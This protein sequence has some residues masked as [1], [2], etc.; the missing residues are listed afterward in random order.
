MAVASREFS[1][2][3]AD[4]SSPASAMHDK[5]QAFRLSKCAR[6]MPVTPDRYF[7]LGKERYVKG[8]LVKWEKDDA[9]DD[10]PPGLIPFFICQ[11]D[12]CETT[13]FDEEGH[14]GR[15]C[16]VQDCSARICV[17]CWDS[18]EHRCSSHAGLMRA[19]EQLLW[20]LPQRQYGAHSHCTEA[21]S[22][23]RPIAKDQL[24]P[25]GLMNYCIVCRKPLFE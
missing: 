12:D 5:F 23:Y 17:P 20:L 10:E 7:E 22:R 8:R 19:I 4:G 13:L 9:E 18:S 15:V 16:E 2:L 3:P 11:V 14:E 24:R 6:L 21:S 1:E 25:K